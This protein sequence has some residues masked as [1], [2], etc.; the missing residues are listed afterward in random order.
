V[1]G[2]GNLAVQNGKL[3]TAFGYVAGQPPR[4]RRFK[5]ELEAELERMRI[6][7]DAKTR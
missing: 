6:F 1:I 5:E 7:L 4:D 2:W 3:T